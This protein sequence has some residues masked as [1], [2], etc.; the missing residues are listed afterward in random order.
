MDIEKIMLI[1]LS[2]G[3]TSYTIHHK[4]KNKPPVI[5]FKSRDHDRIL[6]KKVNSRLH[7]VL[8][9]SDFYST[10]FV[11]EKKEEIEPSIMTRAPT[12]KK[13]SKEKRDNIK[14]TFSVHKKKQTKIR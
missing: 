8:I 7:S 11:E 1:C 6:L 4:C 13:H 3:S 9:K 2:I 10:D 5:R 14:N 12:P